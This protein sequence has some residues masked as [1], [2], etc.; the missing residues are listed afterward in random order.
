[1]FVLEGDELVVH[2][3]RSGGQQLLR[4]ASE[5]EL[6]QSKAEQA[7]QEQ[8][9]GHCADHTR[10]AGIGFQGRHFDE[11]RDV[12]SGRPG[13]DPGFK[14]ADLRSVWHERLGFADRLAGAVQIAG[15]DRRM[16]AFHAAR[17][18]A[19]PHTGLESR[20]TSAAGYFWAVR[21][22]TSSVLRH[23]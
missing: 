7:E 20:P 2:R 16:R 6:G 23:G 18:A 9:H 5:V 15:I 8:K 12:Y 21:V 19:P 11:R 10:P 4:R 1:V 13:R 17:E 14:I 3:G 22:V